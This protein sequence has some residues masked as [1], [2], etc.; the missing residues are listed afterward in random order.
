[1]PG[2]LVIISGPS[3]VGKS[4]ITNA[5][6]KRL[7]AELSISMT[8]RPRAATDVDGKH[9]H[10]VDVPS[11]QAAIA[12]DAFLEWAEVY[13]NYYG[14]PRRFAEERLAAGR[15]VVLEIDADGA[16]QVKQNMADCFAVFILAP[17]DEA[18]LQRLRHRKRD[19]EATIQRR[20]GQAQEE[21]AHARASDTYNAF[22]IND[23]FDRAV[24]EVSALIESELRR[25]QAPPVPPVPPAPPASA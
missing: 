15:V 1:M 16:Q 23:D 13:G 7:D 4:T 14:T 20:F 12:D 21:I 11:F 2:F 19:D 5:V 3:G 25:R 22:V 9:Y 17:G 24:D 8:T 18:L 6:I 10:F